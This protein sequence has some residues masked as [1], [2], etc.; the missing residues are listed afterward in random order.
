MFKVAKLN[1]NLDV[2]QV[3]NIINNNESLSYFAKPDTKLLLQVLFMD[4]DQSNK[5]NEL[6]QHSEYSLVAK[7]QLLKYFPFQLLPDAGYKDNSMFLA[8]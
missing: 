4:K 5:I 8:E 7:Y 3:I 2:F 6:I 1:S